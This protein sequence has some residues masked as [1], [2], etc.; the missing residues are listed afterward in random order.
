MHFVV[1]RDNV[2]A[3]H[4][5]PKRRNQLHLSL[6]GFSCLSRTDPAT[7]AMARQS[8]GQARRYAA[9]VPDDHAR[10]PGTIG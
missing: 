8:V 9:M 6:P 2:C 4:E 5:R 3:T 10:A 7:E 1:N